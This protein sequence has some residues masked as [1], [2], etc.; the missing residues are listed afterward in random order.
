M[1]VVGFSLRPTRL[2]SAAAS[3]FVVFQSI[4]P[5]RLL[6]VVEEDVLGDREV[7]AEG[8]LLMDDDDA[9]GLAVAKA[10]EGDFLAFE[11][12]VA[13]VRAV[14]VDARQ[15]LHESRLAGAVLAAD[16]VDLAALD[17]EVDVRECFHAGEGLGDA[18]HLENVVRHV[19]TSSWADRGSVLER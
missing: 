7:G 15:H 11:D 3:K 10:L 19:P 9:L 4:R 17:L 5:R 12:D 8:E 16:G 2:S 18:A 13:V 1:T 6:L 14:R